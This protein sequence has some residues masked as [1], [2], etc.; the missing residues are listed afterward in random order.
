MSIPEL[1]QWHPRGWVVTEIV[2]PE[3]CDCEGRFVQ[4]PSHSCVDSSVHHALVN[5]GEREIV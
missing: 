3:G 1:G 4:H 5:A 2:L